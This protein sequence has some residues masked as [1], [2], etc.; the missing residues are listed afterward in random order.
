MA[1]QEGA[2]KLAIVFKPMFDEL[3]KELKEHTTVQCQEVMLMMGKMDTRM[4]VLEK[5]VGEKK[6]AVRGEKKE[7][8]APAGE[9]VQVVEPAGAHK[10]F[11]TNKLVWFREL[12][13]TDADFRAKYATA[14]IRA[15]MDKSEEI[16][17]KK[18]D[19]Q[20]YIAE[21]MFCWNFIKNNKK[22]VVEDIDKVFAQAKA[23]HEV[24][25]KP[26]Q[27]AVEANTPPAPTAG[28]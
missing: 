9:N 21:A 26:Q 15:Q 28:K 3:K 11:A 5:L 16:T 12:Y 4:D 10:S 1:A 19:Q 18:N 27:Q 24:A 6:K 23:D 8:A 25:N 17:G 22:D 13:K 7:V 2:Q 20:R 14:E